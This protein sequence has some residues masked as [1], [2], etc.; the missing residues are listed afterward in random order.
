[1][2][3]KFNVGDTVLIVGTIESIYVETTDNEPV[4]HVLINEAGTGT[5]RSYRIRVNED[6]MKNL[7]EKKDG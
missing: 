3:T 7:E 4:Y 2:T 1:M 6:A 5:H